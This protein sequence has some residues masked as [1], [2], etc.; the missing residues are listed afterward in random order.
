[1]NGNEEPLIA[2]CINL[3]VCA[4]SYLSVKTVAQI[5]RRAS[6]ILVIATLVSS[7]AASSWSRV[8]EL[9]RRNDQAKC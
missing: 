7:E 2:P 6:F 1:M 8:D 4:V 9:T 3:T 5:L